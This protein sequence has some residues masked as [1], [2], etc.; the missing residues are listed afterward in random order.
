MHLTRVGCCAKLPPVKYARPP[1][2]I[3][4][5]RKFCVLAL[6]LGYSV[7]GQRWKLLDALLDYAEDNPDLFRLCETADLGNG[8]LAYFPKYQSQVHLVMKHQESCPQMGTGTCR[9]YVRLPQ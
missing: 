7:R 2:P 9:C 5:F 6:K 1:F 4:L 8:C 3:P